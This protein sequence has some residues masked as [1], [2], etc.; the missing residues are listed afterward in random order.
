M[1]FGGSH[2]ELN[3]EERKKIWNARQKIVKA[4][5]LDGMNWYIFVVVCVCL[6]ILRI[7]LKI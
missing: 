5:R 7:A 3:N 1:K 2:V 6:K 4:N